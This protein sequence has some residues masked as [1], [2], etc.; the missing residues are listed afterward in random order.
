MRPNMLLVD[1]SRTVLGFEGALLRQNMASE[2]LTASDGRDGLQP[3]WR[4]KPELDRSRYRS[5]RLKTIE[6]LYKQI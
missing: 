6:Y 3:A 1:D 4:E 5:A 2:V